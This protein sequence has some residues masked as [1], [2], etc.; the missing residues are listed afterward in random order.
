[1]A[2]NS[3]ADAVAEEDDDA[4]SATVAAD[5]GGGEVA[6]K[7]VAIPTPPTALATTPGSASGLGG[8]H[9]VLAE[10]KRCVESAESNC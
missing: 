3:E 6:E 2:S 9:V 1:M 4:E 5:G 7:A 10:G 8:H